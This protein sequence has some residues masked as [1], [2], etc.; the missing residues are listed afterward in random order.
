M[1]G[2][3]GNRDGKGRL[4]PCAWGSNVFMEPR[5]AAGAAFVLLI[6]KAL[7]APAGIVDMSM[8][9]GTTWTGIGYFKHLGSLGSGG[10]CCTLV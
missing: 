2:E 3:E 4:V 1:T 7:H 6:G 8:D 9:I 10:Q 5:P